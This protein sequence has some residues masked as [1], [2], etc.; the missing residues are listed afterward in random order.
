MADIPHPRKSAEGRAW[1]AEHWA[2]VRAARTSMIAEV[3]ADLIRAASRYASTSSRCVRCGRALV[4][5]ESR[6]RGVGPECLRGTGADIRRA[7]TEMISDLRAV[8]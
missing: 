1:L 3:E 6:A 8:S 5:V 7:L 4:D 2:R